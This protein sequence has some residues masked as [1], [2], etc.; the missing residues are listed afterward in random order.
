MDY[1]HAIR[2]VYPDKLLMISGETLD[3]LEVI[4]QETGELFEWDHELVAASGQEVEN[5]LNLKLIRRKRDML[6]AETDWMANSDVTMSDEWG[7]YRQALRDLP[8]NTTDPANPT[9]PTKPA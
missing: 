5:E 4:D 9:W 2:H 3:D 7:A 6:L 8:A 1:H